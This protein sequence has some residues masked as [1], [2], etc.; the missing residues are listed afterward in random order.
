VPKPPTRM[1]AGLGQL[2]VVA[3]VRRGVEPEGAPPIPFMLIVAKAESIGYR[4]DC[5]SKAS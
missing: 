1:T 4:V 5:S 3:C 2:A